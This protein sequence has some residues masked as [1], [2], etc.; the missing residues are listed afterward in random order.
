M[1]RNLLAI[2]VEAGSFDEI[3]ATAIAALA[4]S[5]MFFFLGLLLLDMEQRA[6]ARRLAKDVSGLMT[7]NP[8]AGVVD[9]R[10]PREPKDLRGNEAGQGRLLVSGGGCSC[11]AFSS[12][13]GGSCRPDC[14]V[15]VGAGGARPGSAAIACHNRSDA[16]CCSGSG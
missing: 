13:R 8:V 16:R 10:V 9:Q 11:D 6:P 4:G 3:P 2:L 12:G 5:L 15:G 14:R 7:T 1:N